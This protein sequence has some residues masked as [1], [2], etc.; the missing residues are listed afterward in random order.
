MDL[1]SASKTGSTYASMSFAKA[2]ADEQ[3]CFDHALALTHV[4]DTTQDSAIS[5]DFGVSGVWIVAV[6]SCWNPETWQHCH[7]QSGRRSG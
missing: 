6:S 5:C 4:D 2:S 1:E 7:S 3:H